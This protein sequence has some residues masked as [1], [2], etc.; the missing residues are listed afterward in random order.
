[1][2]FTREDF[3]TM[4]TELLYSE[5]VSYDAMC[6]IA[7][8]TLKKKVAYW[9]YAEPCLRGRDYEGDI[10]NEIHLRLMK[11]VIPNFLLHKSVTGPY[12]DNPEGFAGW[13]CRV[14]ENIKKDFA[15][16]VRFGDMTTRP[17]DDPSVIT[18]PDTG[19]EEEAERIERLSQALSIVLDSDN[20]I[21]KVLTWLAQFVCILEHDVSKIA[22]NDLILTAF[23]DKTLFEMYDMLLCAAKRIPWFRLS[24]EQ[25]EKITAAL[26]KKHHGDVLYGEIRYRDFFIKKDGEPSGKKSVSDW[27]NRM[28]GLVKRKSEEEASEKDGK[29]ALRSTQITRKEEEKWSI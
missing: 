18:A 8:A 22:A 10:M 15:D 4:V 1:M 9:C 17:M 3:D 6:R 24:R 12:N 5:R 29:A 2:N 16:R 25:D 13:L 14:G 26:R 28:N 19:T 23:E 11:T 27:M 7:E 20:S 21:Y